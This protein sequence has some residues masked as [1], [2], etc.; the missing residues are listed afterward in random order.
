AINIMPSVYKCIVCRANLNP[1]KEINCDECKLYVHTTCSNLS[2]IELQCLKSKDRSITYQCTKCK[3]QRKEIRDLVE[4]ITE[5]KSEIE[6]LKKRGA[7]TNDEINAEEIIQETFERQRR[8]CNL[9]I[10]NIEEYHSEDK[11]T[12]IESDVETAKEIISQISTVST[13]DI[14]VTRLGRPNNVGNKRPLR[15]A[16]KNPSDVIDVLRNKFKLKS[17]Y[18]NSVSISADQT[19]RQREYLKNLRDQLQVR[20][21]NGDNVTIRYMN[22]VPKIV[23][24]PKK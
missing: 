18:S 6:S 20:L 23:N 21:A 24:V 15:I 13:T 1:D 2:D 10:Y 4:I 3:C 8:S 5:L 19:P 12:R 17:L 22:G 7:N 9:I 11:E 16:F 14:H